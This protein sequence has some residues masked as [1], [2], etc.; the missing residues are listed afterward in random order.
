MTEPATASSHDETPEYLEFKARCEGTN[1]NPQTLLATDYL[2]HFNE[3]V[4][5]IEMIPDMPDILEEAREWQPKSYPD[6]FRDSAFSDKDL[7]VAAYEHVPPVFKSK[8]EKTIRQMDNVVLTGMKQTEEA[9]SLGEPELLRIRVTSIVQLLHQLG[10]IAGGIINGS[11]TTLRQSEIDAV[12]GGEA[13]LETMA[14]DGLQARLDSLLALAGEVG[15]PAADPGTVQSSI[16]GL[17]GEPSSESAGQAD[18]DALFDGPPPPSS[19]PAGQA[20]ID[21]LF[22]G[23]PPPSSEPAGQADIDALFDGPPPPSSEPAGQADIDA[24]FDGPPPSASSARPV[25]AS[26]TDALHG[27]DQGTRPLT[28]EEIE[29]LLRK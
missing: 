28:P 4:M 6:H 19:E 12:M 20:D 11:I 10:G 26:E 15:G 7:A 8:F 2:N 16:E 1:I 27:N 14:E 23:P 21:A 13:S 25:Y 22:D 24:L 29:A 18:I 3:I 9:L 5:L 17:V